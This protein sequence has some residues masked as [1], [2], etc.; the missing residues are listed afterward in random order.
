[1]WRGRGQATL[2]AFP[3]DSCLPDMVL[4]VWEPEQTMVIAQVLKLLGMLTKFSFFSHQP[5]P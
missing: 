3:W 1:M 4:L 2:Q 5:G